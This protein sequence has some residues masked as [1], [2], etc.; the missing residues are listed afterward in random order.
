M[1]AAFQKYT[2]NAISK[3]INFPS[4]A[5]VEEFNTGYIMAYDLGCKGVTAYRDGSR[6]SQVLV[7]GTAEPATKQ[8]LPR[9][10]AVTTH[11]FTDKVA[12]GCGNLYITVNFDKYGAC[13]VFTNTGKA[14]GC[15][16]Q[17]EASAR[18]ATLALRANI[19]YD[20]II[21]QLSGIRCPAAV[22]NKSSQCLSCP[23][24]IAK[25]LRKAIGQKAIVDTPAPSF[26]PATVI[27]EL[28]TNC[29]EC[30][31]PIHNAEGCIVCPSCGFSK[32]N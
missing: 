22:R 23:D 6:E 27:E 10:R 29:P 9:N 2:D 16:A 13:E 19:D 25:S 11:G 26:G 21:R 3:T 7:L 14:G 31:K 4:T 20:S 15:P 1:Q 32:C 17:S 8:L 12:T 24:A 30:G 28:S 18:L 5:T